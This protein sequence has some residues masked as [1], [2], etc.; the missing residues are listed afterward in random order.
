MVVGSSPDGYE[1][2][3][4]TSEGGENLGKVVPPVVGVGTGAA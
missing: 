1:T 3:D 2:V 4:L